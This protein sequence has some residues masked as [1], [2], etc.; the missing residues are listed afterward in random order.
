MSYIKKLV[1][2]L[3]VNKSRRSEQWVK[4]GKPVGNVSK[5]NLTPKKILMEV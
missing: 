2:F 3:Q 5:K 1:V 4:T